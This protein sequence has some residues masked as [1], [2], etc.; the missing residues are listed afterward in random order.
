MSDSPRQK[1]EMAQEIQL[2]RRQIKQLEQDLVC[3]DKSLGGSASSAAAFEA[4]EKLDAANL[5]IPFSRER[6]FEQ[7]KQA[8]QQIIQAAIDEA[9]DNEDL[10]YRYHND[11]RF[12]RFVQEV[13]AHYVDRERESRPV[14]EKQVAPELLLIPTAQEKL[15][16]GKL[17]APVKGNI[18]YPEDAPRHTLD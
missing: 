16:D 6:T 15:S 7:T 4:A 10:M 14:T 11:A 17:R 8:A 3:D 12:H 18:N 1:Y 13:I 2:L 5:L 9:R